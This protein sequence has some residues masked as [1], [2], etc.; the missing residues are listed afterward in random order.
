[1]GLVEGLQHRGRREGQL[2]ESKLACVAG[3]HAN[4]AVGLPRRLC[5]E[6]ANSRPGF[7]GIPI[8]KG[9]VGLLLAF[10]GPVIQHYTWEDLGAGEGIEPASP[11]LGV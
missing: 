1:M 6:L 9:V 8:L 7:L 3:V 11:A 4:R 5:H 2:I 10:I